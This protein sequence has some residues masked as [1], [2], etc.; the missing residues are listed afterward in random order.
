VKAPIRSPKDFGAGVLYAAFGAGAILLARDYGMGS[1]ARMGPAY[2]PSVLGSLLVLIGVASIVRSL[3]R[4]GEPLGAIAWKPL[5][6][7]AA[8]TALFG[9]LLRGAG[10]VPAIVVLV[11]MSAAASVRFRADWRAAGLMVLLVAFCALVFVQ[12][13]GL[14]VPL[15]GPWFRG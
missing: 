12:G 13:L 9:L 3:T 4:D 11:L 8:A 15:L 14:R 10:L 5:V 6:L 7:V 1:G 2:F